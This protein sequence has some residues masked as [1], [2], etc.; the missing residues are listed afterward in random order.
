MTGVFALIDCN[1]FYVSCERVFDPALEGRPV[2]VLSNNDGCVIARSNEAKALGIGM[3]TALFE[4]RPLLEKHGVRVYSSNYALYGDM[5]N[6][7][8]AALSEFTPNVEVYSIDEAFLDLSGFRRLGSGR[9]GRDIRA[10][11]HRWTGIPVSAGIAA[12]KTLAKLA[13]GIAKRYPE[14]G[15]VFD[16][17]GLSGRRD[18]MAATDIGGVWGIGHR[19]ARMLR[20]NGIETALHFHDAAGP[21][22]RKRMGVAGART[23]LELKGV[24]CF[25]LE[26]QPPAR[27]TTVVSR[28]FRDAI[29][30]EEE[31]RQAVAVFAARAA[32]KLREGGL[33]AGSVTAFVATSRFGPA[34]HQYHNAATVALASPSNH[35]GAVT[36][37][38]LAALKGIFRRRRR[39]KKA[40]VMLLDLAAAGRAQPNLFA[41][42]NDGRGGRL[43][44]ALDRINRKDWGEP[45]SGARGWGDLLHY[46]AAG[47]HRG[48]RMKQAYRS[49]RYTTNWNELPV[50]RG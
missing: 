50:A 22:V 35:T 48:W 33:T 37:A 28:S 18:A 21:W 26:C 8:M 46:G 36:K 13:G 34:R 49:P 30:N 9:H 42:S 29:E 23:W 7:V 3:G 41:P 38:A 20:R 44:E 2:V 40:G 12:T 5:S 47:I 27:K 16:L 14:T 45:G 19:Y 32:E 39:Y 24:A 15:G 10:K 31:L 25:D 43:M 4:A 6:R 1:N 17:T 11:V